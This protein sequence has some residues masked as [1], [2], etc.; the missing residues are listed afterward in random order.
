MERILAVAD[1]LHR[2]L[3]LRERQASLFDVTQQGG[4]DRLGLWVSG[5]SVV[6][7][8]V[9]AIQEGATMLWVPWAVL[10]SVILVRRV[11]STTVA[12]PCHT[13]N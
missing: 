8:K 13:S 9:E 5:P 12:Q 10:A 6:A 4:H 11:S 7:V 2:L 3:D 1:G